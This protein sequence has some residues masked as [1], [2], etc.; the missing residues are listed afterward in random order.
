MH[1]PLVSIILPVYNAGRYLGP[2]LASVLAQTYSNLEILVV[3]DGS[4]DGCLSQIEDVEECKADI[5]QFRMP[6]HDPTAMFRVSLTKKFEFE[7]ALQVGQVYDYVL[8]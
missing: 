4:T 1:S 2:A 8:Q 5:Q 3:D 6:A 7:P